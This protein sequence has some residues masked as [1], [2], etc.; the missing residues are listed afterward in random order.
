[1]PKIRE[2]CVSLL[3]TDWDGRV[4]LPDSDVK[5]VEQAIEKLPDS[6]VLEMYNKAYEGYQYE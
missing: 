2:R 4:V 5:E 3:T 6:I 1:M